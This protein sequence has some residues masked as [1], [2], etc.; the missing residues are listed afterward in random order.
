MVVNARTGNLADD[1]VI[2]AGAIHTMILIR[3]AISMF[4]LT[5]LG[6]AISLSAA[7]SEQIPPRKLR[8]LANDRLLSLANDRLLSAQ[9]PKRANQHHIDQRQHRQYTN[10]C[11]GP[12]SFDQKRTG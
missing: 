11:V 5:L 4:A 6:L 2:F 7:Q 10:G 8:S 12:A 1:I 3:F 9:P